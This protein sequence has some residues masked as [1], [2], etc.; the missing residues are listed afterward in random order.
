MAQVLAHLELTVLPSQLS[1]QLFKLHE[2][3]LWMRGSY[4]RLRTLV[5]TLPRAILL[6]KKIE[7]GIILELTTSG[8]YFVQID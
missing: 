2:G 4:E 8:S 6:D 7:N 5:I 3:S 1:T